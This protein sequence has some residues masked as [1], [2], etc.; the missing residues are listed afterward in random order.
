[1]S[2]HVDLL[3]TGKELQLVRLAID[4]Y[5]SRKVHM[6]ADGIVAKSTLI[7]ERDPAELEGKALTVAQKA[8]REYGDDPG[9]DVSADRV[10]EKLEV[11]E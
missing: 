4:E 3:L 8:V 9:L 10:L 11:A 1:M 5:I 2:Q 7:T 6:R